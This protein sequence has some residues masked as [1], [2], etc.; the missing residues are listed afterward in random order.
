LTDLY[1]FGQILNG[2]LPCISTR[3]LIASQ[4][5]L[6]ASPPAAGWRNL[7][8]ARTGLASS[9]AR[10]P[11]T[12]TYIGSISD[13]LYT[14]GANRRCPINERYSDR[15]ADLTP[16]ALY[17]LAGLLDRLMDDRH[18]ERPSKIN[19]EDAEILEKALGAVGDLKVSSVWGTW[20][21]ASLAKKSS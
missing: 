15:L 10:W 13:V 2:I 21:L 16:E 18:Y 6:F 1:L 5:N 19:T 7:L 8:R 20:T 17:R 14:R 11:R 9:P 12:A 3:Q 4:G